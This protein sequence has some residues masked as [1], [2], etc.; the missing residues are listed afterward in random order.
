MDRHFFVCLHLCRPLRDRR[1]KYFHRSADLV[2][3]DTLLLRKTVEHERAASTT[4]KAIALPIFTAIGAVVLAALVLL[5]WYAWRRHKRAIDLGHAQR[6]DDVGEPHTDS[7]VGRRGRSVHSH[8]I[9][10][11]FEEGD[12]QSIAKEKRHS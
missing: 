7:A 10:G 8:R 5:A 12:E 11:E 4:L 2:P 9:K 3:S 1:A 6:G